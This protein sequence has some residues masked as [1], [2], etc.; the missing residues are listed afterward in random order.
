M[1]KERI[2]DEKKINKSKTDDKRQT[3]PHTSGNEV[4]NLQQLVGNRA[5]QK[6]IQ[7]SG[8][9]P[10]ELDDE[11]TVRINQEREGGQSLGQEIQKQS[12]SA[13]GYDFSGVRIHTSP[14][15]DHLNRELG[16]KAFT[17]G[18]DI[19]F[20]EDAY[21]QN[22]SAGK[23]LITHELTHVVQQGTGVVRN[24]EGGMTVN[25]PG[26]VFEQQADAISRAANN[27]NIS[28]DVQRQD[29]DEKEESIQM[30]EEEEEELAQ[31]QEE[32]ELVQ[33]QEEEEEELAQ[34]QEEEEE[35][36]MP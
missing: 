23:A 5:V 32:E 7:R 29:E 11:T 28:A 16:A 2:T 31:M 4:S 36:I 6:I 27:S 20:R 15:A 3:K 34:M 33:M 19:F 13:L 30:Q 21:D 17:T 1:S 24:N 26:D 18:K 25:A 10:T 35:E 8:I 9:G 22:S 14:D 12:E